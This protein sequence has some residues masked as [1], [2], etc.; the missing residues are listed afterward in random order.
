MA[1]SAAFLPVNPLMVT[2]LHTGMME[3]NCFQIFTKGNLDFIAE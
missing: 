1:A 2:L 3:V